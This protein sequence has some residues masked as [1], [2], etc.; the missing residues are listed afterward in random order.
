MSEWVGGWVGESVSRWASESASE[1]AS[2]WA[3]ERAIDQEIDL[4]FGRVLDWVVHCTDDWAIVT[5]KEESSLGC[6]IF[7]LTWTIPTP[8][9]SKLYPESHHP[10]RWVSRPH[11][12]FTTTNEY[13]T[14]INSFAH[15]RCGNDFKSVTWIYKNIERRRIPLFHDLTLNNGK[16][17]PIWW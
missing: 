11:F 13:F 12:Y 17:L 2:G 7:C 6:R 1:R 5:R 9:A 10:N 8:D 15:G 3:S 14:I 4:V 16:I